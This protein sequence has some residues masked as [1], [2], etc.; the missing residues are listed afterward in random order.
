LFYFIANLRELLGIRMYIESACLPREMMK[1][2]NSTVTLTF[3]K[4]IPYNTLTTEKTPQE[5]ARYIKEIVYRLPC[6]A[7]T[8]AGGT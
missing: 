2:R 6:S 5:W 1:Q 3:G 8:S 7:D 4:M